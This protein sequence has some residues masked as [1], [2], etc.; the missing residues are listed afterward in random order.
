MGDYQ[1]RVVDEKAALDTKINNL[2]EFVD[3]TLYQTLKYFDQR[4]LN[5]QL[6]IMK[7]YS[8]VLGL[9]IFAFKQAANEV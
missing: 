4:L 1:E 9:R 6:E 5:D 8:D 2:E 7:N 3:S